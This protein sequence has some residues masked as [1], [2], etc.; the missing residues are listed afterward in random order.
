MKEILAGLLLTYGLLSLLA[1]GIG[2]LGNKSFTG[3]P[4]CQE[5]PLNV[6]L[7]FPAYKFGCWLM[8]EQK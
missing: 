6:E 4:A 2:G 5:K 1:V 8:R 3:I 7:L